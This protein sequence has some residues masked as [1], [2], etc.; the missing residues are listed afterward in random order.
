MSLFAGCCA[1]GKKLDPNTET[2]DRM[3][4]KQN[5]FIFQKENKKSKNNAY[6][7]NKTTLNQVTTITQN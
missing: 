2:Q 3:N 7:I 4:S 1:G 5:G 6:G